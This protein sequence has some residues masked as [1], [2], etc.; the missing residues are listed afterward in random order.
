MSTKRVAGVD[1]SSS[2]FCYVGL[3]S[4]NSTWLFPV[5]V[6]GDPKK[7][8]NLI[9]NGLARFTAQAAKLNKK[10][11]Y[12][13]WQRLHGAALAYGL[14]VEPRLEASAEAERS[15]IEAEMG[16]STQRATATYTDSDRIAN[17]DRIADHWL[18]RLGLD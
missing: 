3:E 2:S 12:K 9:C 15:I 4:D 10:D 11:R 7:S 17:A 8:S 16:V 5:H 18:E 6:P 1:L 14:T 13:T